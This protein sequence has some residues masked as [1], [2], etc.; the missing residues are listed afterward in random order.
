[1]LGFVLQPAFGVVCIFTTLIGFSIVVSRAVLGTLTQAIPPEEFR[2]RVQSA[3]HI[4][5]S[6]PLAISVGVVGLLLQLVSAYATILPLG[7]PGLPQTIN[8]VN[9][10]SRQWIVFA[11]FAITMLLTAW[12][13]VKILKDIDKAFSNSSGQNHASI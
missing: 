9:S 4:I 12:L 11:G 1:M 10:S 2:G 13:A 3:F 7:L 8:Y 5:T 6:V